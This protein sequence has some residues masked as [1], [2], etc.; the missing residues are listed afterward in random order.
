MNWTKEFDQFRK[1]ALE[2]A[3]RCIESLNDECNCHESY[4]IRE[5]VDP[6][7]EYCQ[8][9]RYILSLANKL[10]ELTETN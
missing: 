6:Q 9:G 7:C 5:T 1:I 10:L 3:D 4:Q 2:L 8:I